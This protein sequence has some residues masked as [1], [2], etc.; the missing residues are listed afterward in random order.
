MDE[1]VWAIFVA[2]NDGVFPNFYPIGLYI[3]REKAMEELE[4]LPRDMN[5]QLLR[6][7][8]N[9]MFPYYHKKNGK[10]VGMDGIHH[11]HIHFRDNYNGG[12]L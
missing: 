1:Y 7:P 2:E 5:Y 4:A 12:G 10:L 3:S 6:L 8:V 9:R 11:E